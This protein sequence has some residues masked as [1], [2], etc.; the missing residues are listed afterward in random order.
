MKILPLRKL[1]MLL[2]HFK[3]SSVLY[4]FVWGL[5][6]LLGV[7]CWPVCFVGEA[8]VSNIAVIYL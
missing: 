2:E 7:E 1:N 5:A 6:C 3:I 4:V 8:I